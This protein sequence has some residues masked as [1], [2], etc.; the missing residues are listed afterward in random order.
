MA[1]S[2]VSRWVRLQSSYIIVFSWKAKRTDRQE[3]RACKGQAYTVCSWRLKDLSTVK[4][5]VLVT[6]W[7][8]IFL[9]SDGVSLVSQMSWQLRAKSADQCSIT[10]AV[11]ASKDLLSER[12]LSTCKFMSHIAY[13]VPCDIFMPSPKTHYHIHLFLRHLCQNKTSQSK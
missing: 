1:R 12:K 6:R 5:K 3:C 7:G 13:F 10:V 4:T 2:L 11:P 9:Y 8:P